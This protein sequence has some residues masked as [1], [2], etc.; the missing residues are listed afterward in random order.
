MNRLEYADLFQSE[1]GEYLQILN[2]C[3]LQLEEEPQ[4][5]QSLQEAFR[6][7]H[8]LKGMAGTMGYRQI[9]EIAHYLENLLEELKSGSIEPS[10]LTMD[11]LFEAVD[12]LQTALINPEQA[13]P[14]E[15]KQAKQIINKI[16]GIQSYTVESGKAVVNRFPEVEVRL[17]EAEKEA[18]RLALQNKKYIY[19][20]R[21]TLADHTPLKSVRVY[22]VL[23]K[24]EVNGDIIATAPALQDLEDE[25]F[26]RYFQVILSAHQPPGKK[27]LKELLS[28]TDVENVELLPW[29]EKNIIEL[30]PD[31]LPSGLTK[32]REGIALRGLTDKMVRVETSKL[33][34]L[35]NLVGEMVVART[36]ILELGRGHSEELDNL[37]DQLKRSINNLQDTSMELRMVPVKQVFDRF[38]R[39]VRDISRSRMKKVRL[40]ISGEQTEL[41]R[42]IVNR[43]SDPLVHLIRNAIDH[44]IEPEAERKARGKSPEGSILLKAYHEGNHIVILVEDD[45]AGI[46]P[47]LIKSTAIDKGIISREEA[48]HLSE[49]ELLNL[50]FYSGF[51]TSSKV[52]DVSG[53]GVGMD[54]VKA[55]IE[56]LHGSIQIESRPLKMTRFTLRL[57]LTLAIIKSLLVNSAG[58]T[59]AIPVEVIR[60]NIFLEV[61]QVKTIR[62]SKV[63]NL[64]GEVICLHNLSEL[65]GFSNNGY[66]G[67]AGFPVVIVEAGGKKAGLIVEK[68]IGQ[69]EIMI[70]PLGEYLKG[71]TGIAGA[72]ILGDGRV[73]LILDVLNLLP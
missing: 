9:M 55:S 39:M 51:S 40:L 66:S 65:L 56:A 44:G 6:A 11:L 7:V 72:T 49:Q 32:E 57:P 1:A 50:I 37:L 54:V 42:S 30:T 60:E 48:S 36:R 13:A 35:M 45:G 43:L 46:D 8:S 23:R 3:A 58:Q 12:L 10:P 67:S 2:R 38:P 21:V 26:D 53:R 27:L 63:I 15:T 61:D 14:L 64:R 18:V 16:K 4:D 52:T 69:Q 20:V 19:A 68:L 62:G 31:R 59:L 34:Q 17:D 29:E 47:Q 71:L 22:M 73:T 33:D 41:D 28:V 70:K 5:K 24:L 25:N